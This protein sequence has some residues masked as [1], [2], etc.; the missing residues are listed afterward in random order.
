MDPLDDLLTQLG[1]VEE[2]EL[3]PIET[4][5]KIKPRIF[6]I[7]QEDCA[8]QEKKELSTSSKFAEDD[9]SDN[10][11]LY[12][13][14]KALTEQ[15]AQLDGWLKK[16]SSTSGP[17]ATDAWK[18]NKKNVL[19]GL[20]KP[21]A[22]AV[23]VGIVRF[24]KF[25]M[26]VRNPKISS[27]SFG[28][29]TAGMKLEKLSDLRPSSSFNDAWVTMAVIIE[30][31][32]KKKSANGND[33]LIWKL[34]DLKDCQ[35]QPVKLLM[36][37]DAVRDHLEIRLGS[38]IGLISAQ[39]ADDSNASGAKKTVA[40]TLKVSKS[41]QIIEIGESAHFGT[42]KGIRQQD[43]QK[44]SNFVNT[45]LS[46]FCVFHVMSAARK[47]SAKRGT[48]NAVSCAPNL[49][50]LSLPSKQHTATPQPP[51]TIGARAGIV[52]SGLATGTPML[53]DTMKP[54]DSNHLT[55]PISSLKQTTK[56]EQN[57]TLKEIMSE[58]KNTFAARQL[59]KLTERKENKAESLEEVMEFFGRKDTEKHESFGEFL[60]A[61]TEKEKAKTVDLRSSSPATSS[62]SPGGS[63]LWTMSMGNQTPMG[64][65]DA[66]EHA[67]RLRAIAILKTK[68]K[69]KEEAE[70]T[71]GVKR[72]ASAPAE[73]LPDAKKTK[74]SGS[75][76]EEIK[77]MLARKSSHHL[78][79]KQEE[80]DA[81]Q[82]HLTGLEDREKVETFT[83][84]LMEVKNVKVVTCKQCKYTAQ[85]ASS[86][87]HQKQ[88]QL[89][90]HTADKRFF[91]CVGC[92]KRTV[93]F[94]MMPVKHCPHCN[95]NKWERVAMRDERKVLLES[96]NLQVRGEERQFVNS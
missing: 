7:Q 96:E 3:Q 76:M 80:A 13:K 42:C 64:H 59:L 31:G 35:S 47:L 19:T 66:Q 24:D 48:F 17:K 61:D 33:F 82:R 71:G 78:E 50:G 92:K 55:M 34:H 22:E 41:S 12:V 84:T 90:K 57:A 30:K 21:C 94:E 88:H 27:T 77:K 74:S 43:G 54:A 75:K 49:G 65:K 69:E 95:E 67:A 86:E 37:G 56:E 72:K 32:F 52:G 60:K 91:K 36:F 26:S 29:F 6:D 40:A 4:N 73:S 89:V 25:Q 63:K 14:K 2:E 18:S 20:T 68:R 70:R 85:F 44:C 15:G 5:K 81:I 8:P 28:A 45:S 53:R 38:V 87:C 10:D 62:S 93:C 11:E 39:I 83:T 9:N 58:R 1:D 16:N 23:C 46:E 79:A 51:Q